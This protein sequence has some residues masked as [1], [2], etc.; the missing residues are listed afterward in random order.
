MCDVGR[1]CARTFWLFT[2]N[3]INLKPK[4]DHSCTLEFQRLLFGVE[5]PITEK[6]VILIQNNYPSIASSA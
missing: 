6:N 1:G 3:D 5:A 4:T 2:S